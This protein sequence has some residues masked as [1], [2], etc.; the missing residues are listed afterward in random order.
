M[1]ATRRVPVATLRIWF[2]IQRWFVGRT[3]FPLWQSRLTWHSMHGGIAA[4]ETIPGIRRKKNSVSVVVGQWWSVGQQ[5]LLQFV[6]GPS[7]QSSRLFGSM[8]SNAVLGGGH[9][10]VF[11]VVGGVTGFGGVG[12]GQGSGRGGG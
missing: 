5:Y 1:P 11:F 8:K 2:A 6:R 3:E 9:D 10:D 7:P 4:I 12:R